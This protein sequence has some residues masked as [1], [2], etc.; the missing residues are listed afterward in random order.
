MSFDKFGKLA[1]RTFTAGGALPLEGAIVRIRGA[2]EENS[3][4]EYSLISD[5]DGMTEEIDLPAPS[6]LLSQAPNPSEPSYG[7]Y[8][9][10]VSAADYYTKRIKNIAIFDGTRTLLPVNMI[11]K[12]ASETNTTYPRDNLNTLVYENERLEQ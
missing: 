4:I 6:A 12:A 9:V 7:V 2:V 11:P 3:E 5:I 10:D 1:V 8:D